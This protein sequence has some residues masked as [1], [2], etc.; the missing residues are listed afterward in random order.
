MPRVS[1]LLAAILLALL[2]PLQ[3][4]AD[5]MGGDG[6]DLEPLPPGIVFG[7]PAELDPETDREIRAAIQRAFASLGDVVDA[8][9]LIVKRFGL[10]AVPALVEVLTA[11]R[12]VTEA[13]NAALT[14]GALRDVYGPALELKPAIRALHR[15]LEGGG[16]M[17]YRVMS[18]LALGCFHHHEATLPEHYVKRAGYYQAVP[19]V[20]ATH[21]R[22]ADWMTKARRAIVQH[23]NDP[24]PFARVASLFALSKM[25]GPEAREAFVTLRLADLTNIQPQR[26]V[27]LTRAF[28]VVGEPA[29]YFDGLVHGQFQVRSTAALAMAVAMLQDEPAEWTRDTEAI[30]A[31]LRPLTLPNMAGADVA[32]A[33]FARGVNAWVH[34]N[35]DEWRAVWDAAVQPKHDRNIAAACAQIL[36]F[37]RLPWFE[38]EIGK[39]TRSPP[40]QVKDAVLAL[41]LLRSGE[42]GDPASLGVLIDWLKSKAKRPAANVRWDPRWYAILGLARALHTGALKPQAD[43]QRVIDAL[44]KAVETT[45][46]RETPVRNVL[47][48]ILD[49]HAQKIIEAPEHAPYLLPRE[50][51]AEIE[52]SFVCPFG[53]QAHDPI[54]ACVDRVDTEASIILGLD[55]IPAWKPGGDNTKKQPERFLR[56]Y[57]DVFPYFTRLEFRADRG[58]REPPAFPAGML[59]LDR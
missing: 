2:L 34:Q 27:L 24:V 57:L 48:A 14:V 11:N 15:V 45:L 30:R 1:H 41:L 51:L 21:E 4:S 33:W 49:R 37:C 16:D 35:S 7:D 52:A 50:D 25:G 17:S 22:G 31:G 44:R 6:R 3:A 8:R 26:A 40:V 43:R 55:S 56:R 23:V 58:H 36:N 29:P 38:D 47:A 59:G 28:L 10:V 54:D 12:N 53:L 20:A 9:D 42:H 32:E 39:W 46:P 5:D 19:G 13:A 18:A